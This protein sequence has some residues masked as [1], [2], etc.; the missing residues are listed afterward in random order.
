MYKLKNSYIDRMVALQLSSKEID[1]I[2]FLATM[3]DDRGTIHSVYYKDVCDTI[4]IS[5]QK[6][7]DL[8]EA[9]CDKG[10]LFFEKK[11]RVDYVVRLADNDFSDKNFSVGYL[12]IASM[13]F[14][15][16]KFTELKA[17]SKLLYLYMQ[18]FTKGKHM[19]VQN[20]YEEFCE[21]FQRSRKSIQA[22]IKELK[23]RYLLFVRKKRNRAYNYEMMF[24]NSTV[25]KIKEF[26]RPHEKDG[27]LENLGELICR[28][29]KEALPDRDLRQTIRDIV[30]LADTKRAEQYSNFVSL[31]VCAINASLKKQKQEA[32]KKPVL[33]AALI[34]TCLTNILNNGIL[35]ETYI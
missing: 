2:L 1:F 10:L 5:V 4:H 28:N 32:K 26:L 13:D 27:Y 15:N 30:S 25:L 6:F 18:R 21:L 20:F 31:I 8:L 7:Y 33:N 17:G 35:P 11:N 12:N 22:Y 19:L 23:E 24:Q 3:Q 9:L 14:A 29:F 34:N 16:K